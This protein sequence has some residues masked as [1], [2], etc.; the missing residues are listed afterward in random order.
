MGWLRE[1]IEEDP[2]HPLYIQTVRGVGY[3]LTAG[4]LGD[5]QPAGEICAEQHPA[6]NPIGTAAQS[7]SDLF[8]GELFYAKVAASTL[9]AGKLAL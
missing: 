3:K 9:L 7:L 1:H 4:E 6:N 8:A 5:P 2:R